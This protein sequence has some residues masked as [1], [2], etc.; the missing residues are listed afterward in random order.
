MRRAVSV[1]NGAWLESSNNTIRL[2]CEASTASDHARTS[3]TGVFMSAAPEISNIGTEDEQIHAG[4][5][6]ELIG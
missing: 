1:R 3:A 5:L 2:P 4:V 6:D